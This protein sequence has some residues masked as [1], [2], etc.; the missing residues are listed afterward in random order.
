MVSFFPGA[1]IPSDTDSKAKSQTHM[2][3]TLRSSVSKIVI[4]PSTSAS[5]QALTGSYQKQTPGL[6]GGIAI[7]KRPSDGV[8]KEFGPIRVSFPIRALL[9]PGIIIGGL[10]GSTMRAIQDFRDALTT[11]LAQAA[12]QPLTN[13]KLASDVYWDLRN[14]PG[15]D[16]KVFALTTPIPSDT[17]A[18]LYV[19]LTDVT[20]NVENKE[21][22]ITTSATAELRRKSD[23]EHVYLTQVQYQD[24][25]VLKNWTANENALWRDYANFARHYI[26][27]EISAEVFG[28][29]KLQHELQPL[30]SDTVDAVKQNEWQGV[31]RSL[32]PTLA[33]ELVLQGGDSYGAWAEGIDTRNI[34]FDVEIYD[35]H[36]LV[37]AAKRVHESHHTVAQELDACETYRWSVRP[38]Y[39]V[40]A[41]IKHGEWMRIDSAADSGNGNIGRKVSTSPAYTQ[42]FATLKVSCRSK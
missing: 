37:Y 8:S 39:S 35:M 13:D 19:S 18:I 32:R 40:G 15:V 5:H 4:L 42:D 31:T 33:W 6:V 22:I 17:D 12:S 29:V 3:E 36:R 2:S 9:I 14:V 27:R 7:G 38:S 26:G 30:Q 41:D 20:I 28:R 25:D 1:A 16:T 10:A 24:R 21:A 23:G 34:S 11:D